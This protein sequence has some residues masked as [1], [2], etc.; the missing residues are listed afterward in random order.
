MRK[1]REEGE[2]EDDLLKPG[3]ELRK[4]FTQTA[5]WGG[6]WGGGWPR[7]FPIHGSEKK[8][9]LVSDRGKEGKDGEVKVS[10]WG[11]GDRKDGFYRERGG[12]M[13]ANDRVFWG[14]GTENR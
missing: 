10:G 12:R 8:V 11:A 7:Q 9:P 6:G 5:N 14:W 1:A 2:N 13:T 4:A 3:S